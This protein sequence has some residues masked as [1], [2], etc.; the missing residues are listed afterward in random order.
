MP[1]RPAV[2][3]Y[4]KAVRPKSHTARVVHDLGLAIIS[5]RLEQGSLLPRD[6]E[7][8]SRYEVSRTV[9]REA[10]KI[11]GAKGLVRPKSRVGTR[12]QSQGVWNLFDPDVLIWHAHTGFSGDFLQHLGEMRAA[13]EPEGAA[14]AARRRTPEDLEELWE[15][16]EM[17]SDPGI[18]P[19]NFVQAD[20]GLHL[21]V[22]KAADNPFLVSV[23]TLI[24]VALVAM[25]TVSSPTEEPIGLAKSVAQHRAS[26]KRSKRAMRLTPER[27]CRPWCKW[28]FIA[29]GLKTRPECI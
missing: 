7:L 17:M 25:L 12:V 15:W 22:A 5:G 14:L 10:L 2:H 21:A 11:L 16:I 4:Q 8:T 28:A 27:R 29:P 13:L 24:E 19:K 18:S 3:Q 20:L 23:S 9:I 1:T 6:G 26:L